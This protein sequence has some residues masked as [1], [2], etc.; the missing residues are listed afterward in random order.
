MF[1]NRRIKYKEFMLQKN[2]KIQTNLMYV[3]ELISQQD[4]AKLTLDKMTLTK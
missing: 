1:L 2:N 3:D 4:F